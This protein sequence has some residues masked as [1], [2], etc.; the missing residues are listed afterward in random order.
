MEKS[1]ILSMLM[2]PEYNTIGS[3]VTTKELISK[4]ATMERICESN[5]FSRNSGMVVSFIFKNRGMIKIAAITSAIAEVTSQAITMIPFLYELPF[6][7]IKCS[8]EIFVRI[9]DPAMIGAV[10]LFPAKK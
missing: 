8:V 4:K 2:A 5:L 1:K 9:I 6:I 7:P 3:K 10:K